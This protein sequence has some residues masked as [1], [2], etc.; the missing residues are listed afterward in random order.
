MGRKNTNFV[1]NLRNTLYE[2]RTWAAFAP[3]KLYEFYQEIVQASGSN[4]TLAIRSVR[5]P[6]ELKRE[7]G[8]AAELHSSG[9]QL[10]QFH[11][12]Q[13][14][15]TR[16]VFDAFIRVVKDVSPMCE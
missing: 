3:G 14:V 16:V 13:H 1:F 7:S 12:R 9:C 15:I 2:P 10:W 8:Q 6:T 5:A 4:R 11:P